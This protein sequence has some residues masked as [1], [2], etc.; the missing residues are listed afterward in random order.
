MKDYLARHKSLLAPC[1]DFPHV[2]IPRCGTC[3]TDALISLG[4]EEF[5]FWRYWNDPS[6]DFVKPSSS[7]A[8]GPSTPSVLAEEWRVEAYGAG[9]PELFYL[10][11]DTTDEVY[12]RLTECCRIASK[13]NPAD[14]RPAKLLRKALRKLQWAIALFHV[15]PFMEDEPTY[16]CLVIVQDVEQMGQVVSAMSE[17]NVRTFCLSKPPVEW[18][19][20]EECEEEARRM[21]E[22]EL[23]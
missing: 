23:S 19:V 15:A 3:I 11:V 4:E 12:W 6:S 22:R 21:W 8:I 2:L 18:P 14:F 7:Q 17:Q 13:R 1:C 10:P 16:Y 5:L 20:T 9:F